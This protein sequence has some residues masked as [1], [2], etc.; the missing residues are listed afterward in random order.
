MRK[1]EQK[2]LLELMNTIKDANGVLENLFLAGNM[3]EFQAILASEQTAA[4]SIGTKL[5]ETAQNADANVV[6]QVTGTVHLLEEYCELLWH[7]NNSQDV[8]TL[9]ENVQKLDIYTEKIEKAINT[10]PVRLEVVFLPYKAS[11]WDCM[12][13]VWMAANEDPDCDAYVIPIP[14][15]DVKDGQAQE[16]HYEADMMPAGIP[17]TDF[18]EYSLEERRPDV[19]Y[20]HNPY[21]GYN[22]VTSVH[23]SFY[24]AELKKYTD[25]L[26][27][28]PY[29]IT[30][31]RMP[32]GH[33]N[34][35]SYQI[36]DKIILQNEKMVEQFDETLREKLLVLGNPKVDRILRLEKEKADVINTRISEDWKK[37]IQG[38][39]VVLYNT[40]IS[41][42][43]ENSKTA[44][45]KIKEIIGK[46]SDRKDVV[47]L[48]R[49][50][51]LTET[52]LKSM[53][54][55]MYEEYMEIKNRFIKENKGI[56]DESGDA[57][58]SATIAD[59]Y[60]GENTSSLVHYFGLNGKPIL[61]TTWEPVEEWTEEERS[62]LY[63]TDCYFEDGYAWF[64]SR[65]SLAYNY[66]SRMNLETGK[67]ELYRELPGEFK[68]PAKGNAY[69]GIS[70]IGN[71]VL[72]APVWCSDIYIYDVNTEQGIKIPLRESDIAANFAK[73]HAYKDKFVLQPCNYSSVVLVDASVGHCEYYDI[74]NVV[75]RREEA[76]VLFGINSCIVEQ[77]IYIPCRYKN[78]LIIFDLEKK[79]FEEKEI[80]G[81]TCGFYSITNIDNKIWMIGF[82]S[83]TIISL[84]IQS[85]KIDIHKTFPDGFEGGAQPFR[86]IVD[87]NDFVVLVDDP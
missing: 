50:H 48:W 56:F 41:G 65:A 18:R 15:F 6:E 66:L 80:D 3:E 14:Y 55:Q 4:V 52:T 61:Y 45:I 25:M 29:Y 26:V 40:S 13:T 46:F 83:E 21:D 73:V 43:L 51:P 87:A 75:N 62:S 33:L 82:A 30:D 24:C 9:K 53:R 70:K 74:P 86:Q 35:P 78:S 38:K 37:K 7:T 10:V 2:Q 49:P 42:I 60:I 31:G 22:R 77:K 67:V 5:E 57:G 19:I 39:K 47:L 85:A 34:I 68:N 20:I 1:F 72:L 71:K 69:F 17:I 11:M 23:P 32:D 59:A 16:M 44:L 76:D 54:P 8:N 81:V 84:D 58:V 64:V 12:E 28:I 36:I 27:Y 79:E 63:F